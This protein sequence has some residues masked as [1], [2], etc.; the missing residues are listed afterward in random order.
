MMR[1]SIRLTAAVLTALT[2][3]AAPTLIGLELAHG[4]VVVSPTP[5]AYIS[6]DKTCGPAQ[7]GSF[8][9]PS[10]TYQITI[11]GHNFTSG[12]T[13]SL[14]FLDPK[15]QALQSNWSV[16]FA[17]PTFTQT[18]NPTQVATAGT[19]YV[20]ADW[21]IIGGLG[22]KAAFAATAG[23][24]FTA[25]F[26]VPCPV[27]PPAPGTIIIKPPCGPI[28]TPGL[29]GLSYTIEIHGSSFRPD[30]QVIIFFNGQQV[31][32]SNTTVKQDGTF[33]VTIRPP[34]QPAS[35]SGYVIQANERVVNAA[36]TFQVPCPTVTYNPKF[37]FL[38]DVVPPGRTT[39]LSG[40]GFPGNAHVQLSWIVG[41]PGLPSGT[42][43]ITDAQG[44][45]PPSSFLIFQHS[46]PGKLTITAAALAPDPAFTPPTA[47]L[48]VVP[49]SIQPGNFS[50]RN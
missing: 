40:S 35:P 37:K 45:F 25:P 21:Q 44:N 27:T 30:L 23:R 29:A 32:N 4:A 47:D 42:V 39:T 26:E 12:G 20:A 8:A 6:L 14:S 43:V 50:W 28:A 33:D 18:I 41:Y 7:T 22:A 5:A 13:L 15:G 31:P 10:P 11:T 17:P 1:I 36:A 38:P 46:A 3:W 16:T 24:A 48:L 19:Y 34:M 2:A 9:G 49:G